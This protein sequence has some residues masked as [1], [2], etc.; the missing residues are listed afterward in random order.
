[1]RILVWRSKYGNVMVL[2]RNPVE[3]G[4]AWVWLMKQMDDNGFYDNA[5]DKEE[6][7][8]LNMAMDDRD[9]RRAGRAAEDL[10]RMRSDMG[11]EYE[12]VDIETAVVPE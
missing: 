11:C 2:A 1:M 8:L 7:D 9:Y 10:V 4:K 6:A 5:L 3:E 12:R